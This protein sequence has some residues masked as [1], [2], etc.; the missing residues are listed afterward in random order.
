MAAL[1]LV[2]ATNTSGATAYVAQDGSGDH[3]TIQEA[4]HATV[5]G[6]SILIAA[7]RYSENIV[8]AGA[9]YLI[10]TA[11]AEVTVIDGGSN[12]R[13]V[14]GSD[15]HLNGLSIINGMA[16]DGNG[17]GLLGGGTARHCIF[18]SNRTASGTNQRGGAVAGSYLIEECTF[19]DN[20]AHETGGAVYGSCTIVDCRFIG[21]GASAGWGGAVH[22]V[23]V[24][25]SQFFGNGAYS[26]GAAAYESALED[27]LIGPQGAGGTSIV[28]EPTAVRDCVL[29][30]NRTMTAIISS[31]TAG[32]VSG[33]T[34]VGHRFGMYSEMNSLVSNSI[35]YANDYAIQGRMTTTCCVFWMNGNGNPDEGTNRRCDPMF[36]N[37][38]ENVFTVDAASPCR[39]ESSSGCGAIGALGVGCA[40][41]QNETTTWGE[42]KARYR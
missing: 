13:C 4:V 21:N 37:A 22:G 15:V 17:G 14:Q 9:R 39:P 40:A 1:A 7:G 34:I 30:G 27:C 32:V 35:F 23:T 29:Y 26:G 31:R 28:A 16:F 12:G 2:G 25:T 33:C 24:R 6:D 38:A 18:K 19:E 20:H 42:L 3:Y 36:C 5:S 10:G 8:V 41:V 11:G